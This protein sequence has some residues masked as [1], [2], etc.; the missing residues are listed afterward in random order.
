MKTDIEYIN[1]L[2]EKIN[3]SDNLKHIKDCIENSKWI[4]ELEENWD[5]EGAKKIEPIVWKNAMKF[6]ISSSS[7]IFTHF[8]IKIFSPSILP[9]SDG[10]LD[11][12]FDNNS[13][14]L[15]INFK[16]QYNGLASYYGDN[17]DYNN[18]KGDFISLT[19]IDYIYVWMKQLN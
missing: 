12:S 8:D 11:I 4:T 6:L 1:I 15:L 18:I 2:D 16:N 13:I 3:I 10:S 7:Y 19:Y 5:S 17:Y 9:C 14:R